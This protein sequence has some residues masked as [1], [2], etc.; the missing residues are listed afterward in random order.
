M[1]YKQWWLAFLLASLITLATYVLVLDS[2]DHAD[3]VII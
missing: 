1:A 2:E 3:F